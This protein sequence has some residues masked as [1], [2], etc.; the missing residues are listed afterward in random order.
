MYKKILVLGASGLIG[1]WV[2]KELKDK[3]F[4][5]LGTRLNNS[6]KDLIRLDIGDY[7]NLKKYLGNENPDAIVNCVGMIGK[8]LCNKK[9][10]ESEIANS[11]GVKNISDLCLKNKIKLIHFSTIVVHNGKKPTPYLEEDNPSKR[12]GDIYNEQKSK[13][14][15]FVE[16][17]PESII[18]RLGDIYGYNYLNPTILGGDSF[19]LAY[20]LLSENQEF[21]VFK[22]IKTNK[23]LVSDLGKVVFELLNKEYQGRINIGGKSIDNFDFVN[24][25]KFYFKLPGTISSQSPLENYPLHKLLDLTKMNNLEIKINDSD[26]GLRILSSTL[27]IGPDN[28]LK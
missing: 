10:N 23:T 5:T 12:E 2:Y 9:T 24:K 7:S 13:A 16:S 26:E 25:I 19:K 17:V 6:S 22:N 28:F 4:D 27:S 21:S 14:E 15:L 11:L 20:N 18:I 1:S 3:G 8:D